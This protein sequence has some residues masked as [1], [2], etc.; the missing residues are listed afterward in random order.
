MLAYA[1]YSIPKLR[2]PL[3]DMSPKITSFHILIDSDQLTD[4]PG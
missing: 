1:L 2:M 3:I 4:Q